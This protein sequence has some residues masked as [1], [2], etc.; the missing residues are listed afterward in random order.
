M[1]KDN[2]RMPASVSQLLALADKCNGRSQRTAALHWQRRALKGASNG[3][4]SHLIADILARIAIQLITLGRHLE[5][6]TTINT[7][8]ADHQHDARVPYA[9]CV[10]AGRLLAVGQHQAAIKAFHLAAS[11][12]FSHSQHLVLAIAHTGLADACVAR[13]AQVSHKDR[14]ALWNDALKQCDIALE[15]DAAYIPAHAIKGE[16]LKTCGRADEAISHLQACVDLSK[17]PDKDAHVFNF[18]QCLE[19][20]DKVE[21]ACSYL[22]AYVNEQHLM[23]TS[24]RS[25]VDLPL[26]KYALLLRLLKLLFIKGTGATL[27]QIASLLKFLSTIPG[28]LVRTLR[29]DLRTDFAYYV[30]IRHLFRGA[31]YGKAMLKRNG[32][33]AAIVAE[34]AKRR[35][36]LFAY[37]PLFV[38]GDSHCL[39][40]AWHKIDISS[41]SSSH[42]SAT[43]RL[44][45]PKLVTG[46]KCWHM[47][48]G[49]TFVT[50]KDLSCT[51]NA[52]KL[53]GAREILFSAGEI[54]CREGISS[55]VAKGVYADIDD[56]VRQTVN[57]YIDALYQMAA[58]YSLRIY[59]LPIPPP[60]FSGRRGETVAKFNSQIALATS[61]DNAVTYI[62]G[63]ADTLRSKESS[64]ECPV[65]RSDFSADTMHLNGHV[66]PLMKQALQECWVTDIE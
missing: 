3:E 53:S 19:H 59:V 43:P 44:L 39:T 21:A 63:F 48:E 30:F 32:K 17:H 55:S 4:G 41:P 13:C 35:D 40:Y 1:S 45:V 65:L 31:P 26:E 62:H 47:Q 9:I 11:A 64:P 51:M 36:A 49:Y 8:L 27:S 56:A 12:G 33:A 10:V 2:V 61:K 20:C 5:A 18:V 14:I 58:H 28:T 42:P 22:S 34:A 60:G 7:L 54:D 52:I 50:S 16:I 23:V 46:L 57:V 37:N 15:A 25:G 38:V 29:A 66:V 24:E 6:M